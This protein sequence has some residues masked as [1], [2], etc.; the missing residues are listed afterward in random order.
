MWRRSPVLVSAV[1]PQAHSLALQLLQTALERGHHGLVGELLRF[2]TPPEE[3]AAHNGEGT[4]EPINGAAIASPF[5]Q[6]SVNGWQPAGSASGSGRHA[7]RERCDVLVGRQKPQQPAAVPPSAIQVAP[8]QPGRRGASLLSY[9]PGYSWLFG[10]GSGSSGSGRNSE[11]QAYALSADA[12]AAIS[13]HA[14]ALL[15]YGA[16]TDLAGLCRSV[17]GVHP[18]GGLAAIMRDYPPEAA[19]L[20]TAPEA[21]SSAAAAADE[22]AAALHT[23][24]CV[25]VAELPVWVGGNAEAD[26]AEVAALCQRLG[27]GAPAPWRLAVAVL[28]VD[29]PALS[30]H[31]AAQPDAWRRFAELVAADDTLAFMHDVIASV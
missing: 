22:A 27:P 4:T 28:L 9:I 5:K 10:S 29:L 16:L 19:P 7:S 1:F 11:E 26:A 13:H 3:P 23:A 30:A 17:D 20:P 21:A 24:L 12:Y 15:D 2:M 6:T 25:A 14:H 18:R 31:R 8:R